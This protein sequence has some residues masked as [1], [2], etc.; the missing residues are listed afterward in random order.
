MFKHRRSLDLL[1]IPFMT[2]PLYACG[3]E[4]SFSRFV[5]IIHNRVL[6]LILTKYTI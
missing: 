2:R 6:Q 4:E 1:Q 3:L 5:E